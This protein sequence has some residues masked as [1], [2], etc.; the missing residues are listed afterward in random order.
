[1]VASLTL[2]SLRIASRGKFLYFFFRDEDENEV[3]NIGREFDELYHWHSL[4]PLSDDFDRTKADQGKII[5]IRFQ[6]LTEN[7]R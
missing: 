3:F 6:R 1:M 2:T 7:F 5:N 4:K